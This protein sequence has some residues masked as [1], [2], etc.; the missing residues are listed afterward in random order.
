MNWNDDPEVQR[1]MAHARTRRSLLMSAITWSPFFLL[2]LF[3]FIFFFI[4]EALGGNRG[5]W[6]LV[7]ILGFVTILL[8]YQAIQPTWDLF[9]KPTHVE[10]Y[11]TRRWSRNDA[12]VVRSHW[13]RM[14]NKQI[15]RVDRDLH[16]DVKQGDYLRIHYYEHSA[17]IIELSK[18]APPVPTENAAGTAETDPAH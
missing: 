14:D 7:F 18:V 11:V 12:L 16:G 15:F 1:E 17:S 4:D 6:F 3:G 10:G 9:S 13:I 5:S 2:S 8:G